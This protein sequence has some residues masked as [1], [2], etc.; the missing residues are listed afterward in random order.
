MT[1]DE[2]FAKYAGKQ[3]YVVRGL[4]VMTLY[5]LDKAEA[6]A[7]I[8]AKVDPGYVMSDQGDREAEVMGVMA[9]I[10]VLLAVG[11]IVIGV[12]AALEIV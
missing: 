5:C 8:P 6:E 7:W 4:Q 12:L 2:I 1:L 9:L 11:M 10:A 3:V